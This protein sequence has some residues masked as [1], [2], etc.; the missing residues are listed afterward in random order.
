MLCYL[1]RFV[2][3]AGADACLRTA[4]ET[5]LAVQHAPLPLPVVMTGSLTPLQ[6]FA[7]HSSFMS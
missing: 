7:K 6:R 1:W 4:T 5:D 3:Y 2:R